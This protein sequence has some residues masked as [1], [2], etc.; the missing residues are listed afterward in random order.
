MKLVL[1]ISNVLSWINLVVGS[2]PGP[3]CLVEHYFF[4]RNCCI[5]F[6]RPG[7]MHSPAQLCGITAPQVHFGYDIAIEQTNS[8]RHSHDGFYGHVFCDYAF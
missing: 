8:S 5:D 7:G 1:T 6:H 3:S 2:L 4:A